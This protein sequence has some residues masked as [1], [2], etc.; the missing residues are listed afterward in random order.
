ME[1]L[2]PSQAP[3]THPLYRDE[4]HKIHLVELFAGAAGLAQGFEDSGAYETAALYDIFKP[5]RD[6]YLACKP[7]TIYRL[8]DVSSLNTQSVLN[9][10]DGRILHGVLGGPPCQGFSLAGKR[11]S[12]A[13]T[14][15]LVEAYGN[16]IEQLRPSFLVMEN[17][18]QLLFHRLFKPLLEN[19]EKHYNVTYGLLNAAR[20]GAPQT[21]HRLFI[22]AYDK[23]FGV[24]PTLPN[25]T[26]GQ[27]KQLLYAYHLTSSDARIELN[28]ESAEMILGADPVVK[29]VIREQ[30]AKIDISTGEAL[31]PLV[32]VGQAISDLQSTFHEG[33]LIE[34][35]KDATSPYQEGLRKGQKLV[36][37]CVARRH[38]GEPLNI[39]RKLREGGTPSAEL[40]EISKKYYS[41]AYARLHR[42]GLA[43]TLTTYFQ[44]AGSG[45]FFHYEEPRTLTIREAARLQGFPDEF[46]FLG[47]L[48]EQMQLVGNA[49]PLPLAR[50]LGNHVLTELGSRL[51]S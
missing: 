40:G 9:D 43:R 13:E 29:K 31:E 41:Q 22:V 25:P 28:D 18:P 23:K 4:P 1:S 27:S 45:R 30:R 51:Q 10:L 49:V 7:D 20:Y 47:S 37:N 38:I 11:Q 17:V 42:A 12:K 8:S 34:Y 5:A 2:Q 15:R 50:A 48:A 21:R 24:F 16:Q 6:S 32:T 35:E 44:N 36:A 39:V 33:E 26:H 14:N 46:V 19:L 3:K